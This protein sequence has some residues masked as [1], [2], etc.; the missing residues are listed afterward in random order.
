M[1]FGT[2]ICSA[3]TDTSQIRIEKLLNELKIS[4][5]DTHQVNILLELYWAHKQS[6]PVT[7][8][9]Y[10]KKAWHLSEALQYNKGIILSLNNLGMVEE[11]QGNFEKAMEYYMKELKFCDKIGDQS[12]LSSSINNIGNIYFSQNNYSKAMQYYERA[13]KIDRD[14]NDD[15]GIAASYNNIGI[16]YD[17][18]EE[19]DKAM[20]YYQKSLKISRQ[21]GDKENVANCLHNIG[22]IY[23]MRKDL[24]T[25]M[26]YYLRALK[27]DEDMG[28]NTGMV[29]SYYVI[30]GL[31]GEM[32]QF[33]EAFEYCNK[34]IATAKA[35]NSRHELNEAY[36]TIAEVYAKNKQFRKAFE[37]LRAHVELKDSLFTE[38]STALIAEMDAKY[39]K[40]KQAQ[41]ILNLKQDNAVQQAIHEEELKRQ[42]DLLKAYIA[43]IILVVVI[44]LLVFRGYQLKKKANALLTQRN[45]HII[46]QNNVIEF[47]NKQITDSIQYAKRIQDAILVSKNYLDKVL[48]DY[49]ILYKP[50]DIVSGDFYWCY[51]FSNKKTMLAAADCTGHGVPGALM[52]MICNSLLNEIIIEKGINQVDTILDQLKEKLVQR[53]DQKGEIGESRDGMDIALCAIDKQGMTLEFAGAKNPLYHIRNGELKVIKGDKQSIS[54]HRGEHKGFQKHTLSLEEND[55]FYLSSDGY[56]DQFGGLQGKKYMESNLRNLLVSINHK[57]M[58]GQKNALE[59]EIVSWQGKHEQI[60]DICVIGVRV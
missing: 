16:T 54:Y 31:Y 3:S 1:L 22:S 44:A 58:P 13:L 47:R 10:A 4:P 21:V 34:S 11:D 43:G 26:T 53:L 5:E 25:A 8:R 55:I 33:Q 45:S 20:E 41:E 56:K 49:F 7:A 23:E 59:Q 36:L 18:M 37:Q 14:R 40:E 51:Q 29:I 24:K 50:R 52:S 32:G 6:S 9:E 28:N 17:M 2:P 38:Q 60:D 46:K 39:E 30:C 35:V 19:Y 27:I 12:G 57:S 15:T 48:I 42:D